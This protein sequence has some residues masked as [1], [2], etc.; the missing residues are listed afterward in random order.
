MLELTARYQLVRNFV[1]VVRD[2]SQ[3]AISVET[4]LFPKGQRRGEQ[5]TKSDKC[6]V[7]CCWL[8]RRL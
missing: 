5:S 7:K 6:Q 2:M 8:T 4:E 3:E 1:G